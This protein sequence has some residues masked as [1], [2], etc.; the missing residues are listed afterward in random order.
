MIMG[1][2]NNLI[3]TSLFG[4]EELPVCLHYRFT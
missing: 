4:P 3:A 1:A 2:N